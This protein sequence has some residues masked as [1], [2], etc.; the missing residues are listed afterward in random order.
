MGMNGFDDT[1]GGDM[2]TT[3]TSADESLGFENVPPATPT[4]DRP[5]AR[6]R[7]GSGTP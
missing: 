4:A 7:K 3:G 1:P 5:A 6:Q 2:T